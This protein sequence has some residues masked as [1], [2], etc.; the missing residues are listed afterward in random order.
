MPLDPPGEPRVFLESD[1]V[2]WAPELSPDGGFVAYATG[3]GI[4]VS[5]FPE[6]SGKW[7]VSTGEGCWKGFWS[8]AGDRLFYH[9]WGRLMEVEAA[10]DPELQFGTPRLLFDQ[11]QEGFLPGREVAIAEDGRSFVGVRVLKPDEDVPEVREGI[12]VVENWFSEF[13]D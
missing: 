6:G 11:D 2:Y 7:Q 1:E 13:Q 8:P 9:Q 5:T 4:Y 12:H 3:A 10:T